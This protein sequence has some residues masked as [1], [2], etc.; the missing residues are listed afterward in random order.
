MP[1]PCRP[2][3]DDYTSWTAREFVITAWYGLRVTTQ[4]TSSCE[5]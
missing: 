3:A 1:L 2:P 5:S 4:H